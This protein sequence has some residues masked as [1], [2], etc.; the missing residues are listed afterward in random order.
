[1]PHW[2]IVL[3]TCCQPHQV[4]NQGC[5]RHPPWFEL[6]V[7]P[8]DRHLGIGGCRIFREPLDGFPQFEPMYRVDFSFP[9]VPGSCRRCWVALQSKNNKRHL[10]LSFMSF[11]SF[12]SDTRGFNKDTFS[13]SNV[14]MSLPPAGLRT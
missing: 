13:L 4:T 14:F 2:W 7:F 6:L 11:M 3:C 10:V 1:M 5:S 12:S 8:F 9:P